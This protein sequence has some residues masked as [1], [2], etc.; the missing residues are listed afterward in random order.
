MVI[1]AKAPL[2]VSFAGG[3]TDVAP[4]YLQEGGAVLSSTI[5]R[6]VYGSLRPRHDGQIT[7]ESVDLGISLRF[8]IDEEIPL[9]GSLDLVKAAI[10][11]IGSQERD[12]FDLMVRSGA[13]PGSGL[14]SSSALIVALVA[15]LQEHHQLP[16]TEYEAARLAYEIERE[17]LGIHGGLQ[18]HYSATFGGFNFM[19]FG[20]RVVVN[21]LRVRPAVMNELE[22]S[23]MLC[24]TGI[25]R[26]S[27]G[28]I[29]DQTS[30]VTEGQTETLEGMRAQKQLAH[31]MKALLLRGELRDFGAM[32]DQ[33]WKEK[34][35]MSPMI[36]NERI[37]EA[38]E[39][40]IRHGA[41]GGKVTGAGGGGHILFFCDFNDKHRVA[42]ALTRYG[43]TVSEFSFERDGV[44][45]WRT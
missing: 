4:F 31:D 32:L 36:T 25:T 30:R 33:A 28:I 7:I 34:K 22:I 45:T 41:L 16:L 14:G 11:R 13:P 29:V 26:E 19:E 39:I 40:A 24:F 17:D 37:D 27:A 10:L 3:G 9:D 1:R 15:L 8:A 5:N 6:Y 43:S 38:Y 35:R 18:D 44:T 2:R 23:L 21:P 12:G 20:E 42:D